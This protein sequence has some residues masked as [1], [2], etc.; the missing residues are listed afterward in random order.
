M[1]TITTYVGGTTTRT[2]ALVCVTIVAVSGCGRQAATTPF[3]PAAT[4]AAETIDGELLRE[5][6]VEIADDRYAGRSPGSDGDRMTRVYL[7]RRLDELGFEPGA[8]DGGWQQPFELIGLN[9]SQPPKWSFESDTASIVLDQN[10]DFIVASGVQQDTAAVSGAELV[11]VGYGIEAPEYDWDDF[12]GQDLRGKM[13]VMLNN[14]PDWDPDLFAGTTRLYYGR[15]TYK[16]E[17]AARQGAAGA[18]IIHTAPSAGYPWQVVQSSWT[19]EQFEL[20]AGD[21]PRIALKAW[22]TEDAARRLVEAAGLDLAALVE[23]AKQRDFEPVS[24]GLATSLSMPVAT[25]ST[26]TANIIGVLPGSDPALA[27]EYVI[28]TAHHD[29]LGVGAPNPNGDA[30]DR[31]YN[32][33]RD[34]ASGVGMLFEIGRAFMAL[35]TAPRRSI[36]LLFVAAEE[37]GLLGS[38]YFA[39]S[40]TVPPG[41]IAANVNFDSGNIWGRASDM[42]F[43]GLGKSS[44]DAVAKTVADHQGRTLKPDEFPDRGYFYRSDQFNFAK[45]GV[46]AFYFEGGTE[47]VGQPEGWGAEQINRYT[48]QNYHQPSDEYDDTWRL[49]GMIED[50][51]FGF[52]AGLIVANADEMPQWNPGDEFEATRQAALEALNR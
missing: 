44:L 43:V 7:G 10:T 6:V 35:D 48:E 21:E 45:I 4:A 33:A 18:I 47:I 29:H 46:P 49:D 41:K 11:F 36:M 5:V 15:W 42:S 13:L 16:Y 30:N 23:A 19:G 37:Q 27:D 1:S 51:R 38:Q 50:A 17:S 34:N 31:I 26:E 32:G 9:A 39:R 20:P 40:P 22:V 28:Y 12:K 8:P 25:A 2:C 14:D 24:L 3:T 52:W